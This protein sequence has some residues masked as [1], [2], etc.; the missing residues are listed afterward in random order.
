[1][2]DRINIGCCNAVH[3]FI[4][5]ASELIKYDMDDSKHTADQVKAII[6]AFPESLSLYEDG[7]F[8]MRR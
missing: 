6:D 7:D 5:E 2:I 8:P 1:M 4:K 3:E